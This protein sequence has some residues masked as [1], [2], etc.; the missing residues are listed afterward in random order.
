MGNHKPVGNNNTGVVYGINNGKLYF[1]LW[2]ADLDNTGGS[3]I[4]WASHDVIKYGELAWVMFTYDGDYTRLYHDGV[5]ILANPILTSQIEQPDMSGTWW[6]GA[7][8]NGGNYPF[9]GDMAV[10][11]FDTEARTPAEVW[12]RMYGYHAHRTYISYSDPYTMTEHDATFRLT[13]DDTNNRLVFSDPYGTYSRTIQ[14]ANDT[15]VSFQGTLWK[16][17]LEPRLSLSVTLEAGSFNASLISYV[18]NGRRRTYT[19]E[20]MSPDD[21]LGLGIDTLDD[22][23]GDGL[24]AKDD[25]TF[26]VTG[27]TQRSA[28]IVVQP[29]IVLNQQAAYLLPGETAWVHVT[30]GTAN[31]ISLSLQNAETTKVSDLIT[32]TEAVYPIDYGD[33]LSANTMLSD[34]NGNVL[35]TVVVTASSVPDVYTSVSSSET[36][37]SSVT[38]TAT[39]IVLATANTSFELWNIPADRTVATITLPPNYEYA[40]DT[41]A[42]RAFEIVQSDTYAVEVRIKNLGQTAL[43]EALDIDERDTDTYTQP[44]QVLLTSN[45]Q[46]YSV[47]LGNAAL[48]YDTRALVFTLNSHDDKPG[49]SVYYPDDETV[50]VALGHPY[51]D[52]G[53]TA[54][55]TG[56]SPTNVYTKS[57]PVTAS[58]TAG[59]YDVVYSA[60]D[61]SGVEHTAKRR[62]VVRRARRSPPPLLWRPRLL[63]IPPGITL[64]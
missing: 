16:N 37:T 63:W 56:S 43:T 2:N 1:E 8:R 48:E 36:L 50:Y 51:I 12:S 58:A 40:L 31:A 46:T 29:S 27:T 14:S 38:L 39:K 3:R 49:D 21:T 6:I 9:V 7:G 15:P 25:S 34:D 54:T 45:G 32:V 28:I 64:Q 20:F 44:I 19:L 57:N 22:D 23:L 24:S 59:E 33:G 47:A 10:V 4:S 5:E 13:N 62:V 35:S 61:L 11:L 30:D 53:A 52:A 26:V 55:I 17:E 18:M 42:A 60:V 41:S